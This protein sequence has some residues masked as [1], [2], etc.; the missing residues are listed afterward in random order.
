VLQFGD[1][2]TAYQMWGAMTLSN[3]SISL[4]VIPDTR[5]AAKRWARTTVRGIGLLPIPDLNGLGHEPLLI[6]VV[7]APKQQA[8]GQ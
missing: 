3:A 7:Q 2:N 4:T 8:M 5:L 1:A 6:L